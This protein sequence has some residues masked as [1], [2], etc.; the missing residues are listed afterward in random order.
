[1][2]GDEERLIVLLE[3]KISQFEKAM[4]QAEKAGTRTY[5]GLVKASAG[6]TS[7][8]ER[9]ILTMA[10]TQSRVMDN[11][12]GKSEQSLARTA[13][14]QRSWW[15][16]VQ[17]S[18]A[19][20]DA[21][22]ASIDPLF[23][24]S[25]RYEA[26]LEQLT[27]AER[28]GAI[29]EAQK[30]H[31]V[32]RLSQ[33]YLGAGAAAGKLG[34]VSG[35]L[36][37][38]IQGVSYQVQDMAVQ[39]AAGTSATQAMS[40]QLPQLLSNFGTV[41]VLMGTLAAVGIPVLG[42]AFGAARGEVLSFDDAL[43]A[44]QNSVSSVND[45]MEVYSAQGLAD[46]AERFGALTS[47][48]MALVE[49]RRQLAVADAFA[50]SKETLQALNAELLTFTG[51][52]EQNLARIF[53]IPIEDAER[54]EYALRLAGNASTF[55]EQARLLGIVRA[56]MEALPGGIDMAD[57][58][59]R[60]L[61]TRILDSEEAMAEL[62]AKVPNANWLAAAIGG[63]ED[64]AAKLWEAARAR[65]AALAENPPQRGRGDPRQYGGSIEDIQ[66]NNFSA[67]LAY[68]NDYQP[69]ARRRGRG[70]GGR[71][72]G[73]DEAERAI[74]GLI[75]DLE[76]ERELVQAWYE[77]S[78]QT[79]NS[80]TDQQLEAVGGRHEALER[81]EQEHQERLRG[82]RDEANTGALANAENFFGAMATLAA[83]GGDKT[84]KAARIFGA[85]EALINTYR[86]QAQVLADP[87]LSF[88]AKLPAAAAIGA[89]GL[90]L[91]SAIKGGGSAGRISG[92]ASASSGSGAAGGSGQ[93]EAG[94]LRITLEPIDPSALFTGRT[95]QRLYELLVA[96][97]GARGVTGIGRG[98]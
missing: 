45:V 42:A 15:A 14:A 50:K 1:M 4:A 24:A 27:E 5:N 89:A 88:W 49:A 82:I 41:G 38:R 35:E 71:G 61:Y 92:A 87:K 69:P 68:G 75:A 79:L 57:K 52:A 64:L 77:E 20:V 97:G 37:M 63:A 33:Q 98:E 19:Q 2:A 60:E 23:A 29:T 67:Q 62:A 39:M 55:E 43:S 44:V 12:A 3:G 11:V 58:A 76:T 78:L 59:Q 32:E 6:A 30:A 47:E 74:E 34:Q 86:A 56:E 40:Q 70:S 31:L 25:K 54:L 96:E 17:K 28:V 83:A 9:N 65:A 51:T 22:R 16:E 94:P 73:R 85:A 81:L 90:K 7:A 26:A 72:G 36:R 66:R 91:V 53:K 8:V 46:L 18:Q 84:V 80:A 48:V 13:K 21:L 10:E 93:E 95:V